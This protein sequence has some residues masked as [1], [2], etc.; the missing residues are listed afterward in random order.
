M[1]AEEGVVFNPRNQADECSGDLD[2]PEAQGVKDA[3]RSCSEEPG[4][5]EIGYG[6]AENDEPQG[7]KQVAGDVAVKGEGD[8]AA[9]KQKKL[10]GIEA[11]PGELGAAVKGV[12]EHS[13]PAQERDRREGEGRDGAGARAVGMS[14][15]LTLP[16]TEAA[17][18]MAQEVAG[19]AVSRAACA[20]A[21]HG[22]HYG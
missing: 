10:E 12:A 5:Q 14:S 13:H 9:G 7:N 11:E 17:Q 21:G 19:G 2:G 22:V 3:V 1:P 4:G 16:G 8:S 15:K 18:G 6:V 20:A